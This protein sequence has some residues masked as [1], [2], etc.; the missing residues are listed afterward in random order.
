MTQGTQRIILFQ[1]SII[2]SQCSIFNYL[3][4]EFQEFIYELFL[5]AL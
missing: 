4:L 3:F 5:K 1:F 2:N